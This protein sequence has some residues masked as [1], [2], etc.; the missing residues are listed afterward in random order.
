MKSGVGPRLCG[1]IQLPFADD[2]LATVCAARSEKGGPRW[3]N[4]FREGRTYSG[5]HAATPF[6]RLSAV[7][8][9]ICHDLDSESTEAGRAQKLDEL[10]LRVNEC[11]LVLLSPHCR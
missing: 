8:A 7:S 3:S 2:A 10:C 1:N 11:L 5:P 6:P 9:T 4:Y